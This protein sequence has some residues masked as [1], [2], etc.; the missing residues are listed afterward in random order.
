MSKRVLGVITVSSL[1]LLGKQK[2]NRLTGFAPDV[3]I[4]NSPIT[5][6]SYRRTRRL[7]FLF[8]ALRT[9]SLTAR[10]ELA[11]IATVDQ[12]GFSELIDTMQ[13]ELQADKSTIKINPR[14]KKAFVDLAWLLANQPTDPA[15]ENQPADYLP[16]REKSLLVYKWCIRFLGLRRFKQMHLV[17]ALMLAIATQD[18]K[19]AETVGMKIHPWLFWIP[20]LAPRK[21]KTTRAL[22][23]AE[24]LNLGFVFGKD[25]SLSSKLLMVDS[26]NPFRHDADPIQKLSENSSWLKEF[27]KQV[28]PRGAKSLRFSEPFRT[29]FDSLAAQPVKPVI[30][31]RLI[32]VLVS[33]YKPTEEII[34]SVQSI[35]NSSYQNIEVLVVDDA[36]PRAYDNILKQVENLDLRVRVLKQKSNGGTYRIRNRAM[37]EAKGELITFHDS[38]DWMHPQRLEWQQRALRGNK[39]ANVSMSTRVTESLECVESGRRLR[40]G[41]CEPSLMF[42]KKQVMPK[43]GFFD[44]VRKGADSEY[45]KRIEKAFGQD[46]DIISPFKALTLQRADHGGLTDGDL[47]FRWIVDFRLRY[48]DLYLHWHRSSESLYIKSDESRTFYA[49]RPMRLK[50]ELAYKHREFDVLIAANL[51]DQKNVDFI[52]ETVNETLAAGKSLGFW[53]LPTMYPLALTRSLRPRVIELLNAGKAQLVYPQDDLH[54][55]KFW[56]AAP[57]AFLVSRELVGFNWEVDEFD[58]TN[59]KDASETWN[60]E[61]SGF[62]RELLRVIEQSNMLNNR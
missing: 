38:D 51:C 32:T 22:G 2:G 26:N 35:L 34:S 43:I 6:L 36:S 55:A 33:C 18:K 19:L 44:S 47:S 14:R 46:L 17:D 41:I 45:R 31:D 30:G 50:K 27:S 42:V 24:L 11:R 9:R 53:H 20:R 15:P 40:I 7:R 29:P 48:K 4:A 58:F 8:A 12:H 61:E 57:S 1:G 52:S 5:K 10:E 3:R 21:L 59:L 56:L 60:L 49:P 16:D 62:S 54:A 13:Q 25:F 37:G 39:V 23:I 28:L